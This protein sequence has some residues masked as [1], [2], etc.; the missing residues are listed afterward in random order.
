MKTDLFLNATALNYLSCHRH[1]QVSALWGYKDTAS[2]AANFGN[3]FHTFA[4]HLEGPENL[5]VISQVTHSEAGKL[6]WKT[7]K[8]FAKLCV[9]YEASPILQDSHTINDLQGKPSLEYKFHI[10]WMATD[11]YNIHLVGTIDRIDI[12]RGCLRVL[13][14]KTSRKTQPSAV[15]QGYNLQVQVPFYMW[16]WKRFLYKDF[17][18]QYHNLST[19][20]QYLGIFMSFEPAKFELGNVIAYSDS[21][22][23][24]IEEHLLSAAELM[25]KLADRGEQLAAPTGMA[26]K[27][28][29]E[30]VCKYCFLANLCRCRDHNVIIKYLKSLT[31][32]PYDP[33]TWR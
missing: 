31:P 15:L 23:N 11:K 29:D 27:L 13:D 30:T 17:P 18:E 1:Y 6:P 26:A 33:R 20:G 4:Y 10:P 16:I 9:F 21:L 8:D 12:V 2:D 32:E 25:V 7:N 5:G 22:A 19:I 14:R 3:D 24:D 28:S